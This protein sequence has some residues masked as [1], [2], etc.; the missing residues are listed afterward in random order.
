METIYG[1]GDPFAGRLWR[2]YAGTVRIDALERSVVIDQCSA[3]V[4]DITF[5]VRTGG[6]RT[7]GTRPLTPARNVIEAQGNFFRGLEASV[8]QEGIKLPVLIWEING[9]LYVRYGASRVYVAERLGLAELPAVLCAFGDSIPPGFEAAAE[10][11]TPADILETGFRNPSV[12]GD[13][14]A[15]HERLNAHRMEP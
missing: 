7:V 8:E 14:E 15:S 5:R 11:F 12:V 13:F 2:G 4:R 6:S 10:L 9:K 3:S 1:G